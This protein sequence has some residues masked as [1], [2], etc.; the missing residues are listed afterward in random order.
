MLAGARTWDAQTCAPSLQCNTQSTRL[1]AQECNKEVATLRITPLGLAQLPGAPCCA[2]RVTH[3]ACQILLVTASLP[4]PLL[5]HGGL[6]GPCAGST[7]A[8]CL[9]SELEVHLVET[10]SGALC[11]SGS[12]DLVWNT[13]GSATMRESRERYPVVT[14]V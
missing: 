5:G 12:T 7:H 2:S 6:M 14:E 10:C 11:A 1:Q 13:P 8:P 4:H 3:D 9:Q